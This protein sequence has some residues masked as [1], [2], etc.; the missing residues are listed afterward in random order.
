MLD[1]SL[2]ASYRVRLQNR[3]LPE[4]M[5]EPIIRY[6]VYGIAPGSFLEA[7]LSNDL[8]EA[9]KRCDPTN[10]PYLGEYARFFYQHAPAQSW[11]APERVWAWI[12]SH[13]KDRVRL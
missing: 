1:L 9:V 13:A 8:I 3:G 2:E 7:V 11:G 10:W 5:H 12:A 4:E 6:L